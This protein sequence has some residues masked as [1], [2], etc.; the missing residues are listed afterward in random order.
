MAGEVASKRSHDQRDFWLGAVGLRG[1]GA[2][3][4]ACNG[5]AMD[6]SR[7][8]HAEYRL[9]KRLD[10]GATVFVAR[11]KSG[12]GS[13][14]M[15]RPCLSCENALRARNVKRVYYTISGEEYGIIDF[16]REIEYEPG[17]LK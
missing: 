9:A 6:R 17:K 7:E 14:A 13:F 1:D 16:C 10:Y 15:A 12:D 11:I 8:S 5:P 4:T 2:T 3:V